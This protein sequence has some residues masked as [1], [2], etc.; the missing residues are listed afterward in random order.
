MTDAELDAALERIRAER[1]RREG[2]DNVVGLTR[3]RRS[4]GRRRR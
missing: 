2:K 4:G 3:N 1:N